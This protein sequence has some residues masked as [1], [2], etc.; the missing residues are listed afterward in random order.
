MKFI[1]R[2]LF[3]GGWVFLTGC[4]DQKNYHP[5]NHTEACA[6]RN[7]CSDIS[8]RKQL[9]LNPYTLGFIEMDDQGM[10]W[11]REQFETLKNYIQ[12]VSRKKRTLIYVYVHGWQH[13]A[14]EKDSNVLNFQD[15]LSRISEK[16]NSKE[17]N[18]LGIYVG[19]RGRTVEFPFL[20]H[21]TFWDRQS[22]AK[23]VSDGSIIELFSYLNSIKQQ[24]ITEMRLVTLG[25]SFGGEIVF[26]AINKLLTQELVESGSTASAGMGAKG[27]GDL[28][29]LINPAFDA[30]KYAHFYDVKDR[31]NQF[32]GS[33]K[34]I[35][36]LFTSESDWATK[37][38]FPLGNSF[39]R[40]FEATRYMKAQ[41]GKEQV[42]INQNSAARTAVGHYSP[43][44]NYRLQASNEK[45][46]TQN[47]QVSA[48]VY[49]EKQWQQGLE[50]IQFSTARL[51][52]KPN[53]IE[54]EP[55]LVVS[56][57]PSLIPNHNDFSQVEF[58]TFLHEFIL[59]SLF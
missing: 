4:L 53:Q 21:F 29:V 8:I 35:L 31:Y 34:P 42:L 36:A 49:A 32:L 9:G 43:Y 16:L 57:E 2:I 33:Q 46:S 6:G 37:Y 39:T 45:M 52:R 7:E 51:I 17:W 23:R 50:S 11:D 12:R 59:M 54:R 26:S 55:Y 40:G 27:I 38:A 47:N 10:F 5:N 44:T 48:A 30:L 19:W 56:V 25:H 3:L 24:S 20:E 1:Y 22:A 41:L 58:E 28:T 13:N 18:V 15:Q 14:N